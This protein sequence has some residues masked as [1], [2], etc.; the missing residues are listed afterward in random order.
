MRSPP[1]ATAHGA[2]HIIC[3]QKHTPASINITLA[4]THTYPP[5]R[6]PVCLPL[7]LLRY[8]RTDLIAVPITTMTTVRADAL[9]PAHT[10]RDTRRSADCSRQTSSS[11]GSG[12]ADPLSSHLPLSLFR[13]AS[14]F[15]CYLSFAHSLSFSSYLTHTHGMLAGSQHTCAPFMWATR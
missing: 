11:S 5:T 2:K 12:D 1:P 10:H 13:S 4:H 6:T 14:L 9:T 8:L 15:S 3:Y 7:V